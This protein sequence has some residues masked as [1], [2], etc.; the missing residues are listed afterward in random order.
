[1][2]L[3]FA[4]SALVISSRVVSYGYIGGSSA[5]GPNLNSDNMPSV[6]VS[7]LSLEKPRCSTVFGSDISFAHPL[8]SRYIFSSS[9]VSLTIVKL[10]LMEDSE[11]IAMKK[12]QHN[13]VKSAGQARAPPPM[14]EHGSIVGDQKVLI[15]RA[16]IA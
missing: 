5:V 6:M 2:T 10:L 3:I 7:R 15:M 12:K 1:M 11:Q 8:F 13:M 14:P 9:E 4:I 16:N